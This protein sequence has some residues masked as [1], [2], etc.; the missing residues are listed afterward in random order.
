MSH[1]WRRPTQYAISSKT[2]LNDI[3]LYCI[4]FFNI[5]TKKKYLRFIRTC[6]RYCHYYYY[7]WVCGRGLRFP[8]H[9][10]TTTTYVSSDAANII[11]RTYTRAH[12]PWLQR[13]LGHLASYCHG[14]ECVRRV[15]AQHIIGPSGFAKMRLTNKR[16]VTGWYCFA[17]KTDFPSVR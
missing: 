11:A 16:I 5:E 7:V 10:R 4:F 2:L 9:W 6:Y 17:G 14:H 8:I 1:D 13:S 3:L 15:R 12:A